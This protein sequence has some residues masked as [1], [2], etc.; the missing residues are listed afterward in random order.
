MKEK[1]IFAALTLL[2]GTAIMAHPGIA[3]ADDGGGQLSCPVTYSQLKTALVAADTVDSS[4]FNNHFWAVVVNRAGVV[5]AVAFSGSDTGSQ[6]LSSRQIA[7]AKAFTANGL[8]LDIGSA[9]TGALSTAQLYQ[10]VQ[11]DNVNVANPLYGLAGGNVLD[12]EAAY[13][14]DYKSFGT[15][16]DPMIGRRVGGT[17]TFG[18]GLGLYQGNT[19]VGGV[20]LSGDTACADHSVAWRTRSLLGL[21]QSNPMDK[22]TFATT[23]GQ[24][25]GHPCCPNATSTQ[26]AVN[27]SVCTP[28]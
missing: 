19:V 21:Q 23:P 15:P 12:S 4:G 16:Y 3:R 7:A 22:I 24:P 9:G 14:G 10:F 6:W 8:S 18:G 11:P 13:W 1:G 5:C 26:G 28:S 17:I 25:N 2:A 20:G 27:P